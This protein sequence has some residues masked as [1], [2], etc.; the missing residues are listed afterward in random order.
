MQ[1]MVDVNLPD[2]A[3]AAPEEIARRAAG[4]SPGSR[5]LGQG[6]RRDQELGLYINRERMKVNFDFWRTRARAEQTA[7]CL[8]AR[9]AIHEG[10]LAF[11]KGDLIR[12]KP[13]YDAGLAGW[14]EV[15]EDPEFHSLVDDPSLDGDLNDVID[16]YEK[17]LQYDL[18]S[19]RWD[20]KDPAKR[21]ILQDIRDKHRGGPPQDNSAR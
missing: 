20:E 3:E 16:R 7:A 10:D 18:E 1:P 9:K 19:P 14:H 6:D 13:L 4:P 17:C 11:A 5:G 2:R 15:L 21:F 12:A 8:A